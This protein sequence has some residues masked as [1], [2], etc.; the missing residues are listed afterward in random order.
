MTVEKEANPFSGHDLRQ[1]CHRSVFGVDVHEGSLSSPSSVSRVPL[2]MEKRIPTSDLDRFISSL[3]GE[4]WSSKGSFA[5]QGPVTNYPGYSPSGGIYAEFAI[6]DYAG[7][8]TDLRLRYD[9]FSMPALE[10]LKGS[11][12]EPVKLI[13]SDGFR[14]SFVYWTDNAVATACKE[15]PTGAT[16]RICSDI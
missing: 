1:G 7:R 16:V 3:P 4:K 2:L 11:S 5:I 13:S 14:L 15:P 9:G 10:I 12:F 8:T 6:S